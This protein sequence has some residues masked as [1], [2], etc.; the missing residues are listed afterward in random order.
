MN[1]NK[2]IYCNFKHPDHIG[3]EIYSG[4]YISET[5]MDESEWSNG[6]EYA[7]LKQKKQF[8]EEDNVKINIPVGTRDTADHFWGNYTERFLKKYNFLMMSVII[9]DDK[10]MIRAIVKTKYGY[11][12][13]KYDDFVTYVGDGIWSVSHE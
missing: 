5:E 13:V 8:E 11:I 3:A 12:A 1:E 9:L 7:Y 10:T 2:C 6:Y 4:E